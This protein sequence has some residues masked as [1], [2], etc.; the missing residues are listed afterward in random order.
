MRV[1]LFAVGTGFGY[2]IIDDNGS[3][4]VYQEFDPELP[5]SELMTLD[6]AESMGAVVLDRLRPAVGE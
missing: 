5:G 2:R 6:R 4:C 1:E 3:D